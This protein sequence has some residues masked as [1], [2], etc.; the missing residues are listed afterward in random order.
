MESTGSLVTTSYIFMAFTEFTVFTHNWCQNW[1]QN[2]TY[3]YFPTRSVPLLPARAPALGVASSA[4]EYPRW[5]AR[6]SPRPWPPGRWHDASG[7]RRRRS[8]PD[9]TAP[10][11]RVTGHQRDYILRLVRRILRA[12]GNTARLTHHDI[13][14]SRLTLQSLLYSS[15]KTAIG[16]TREARRAGIKQATSAT[17]VKTAPTAARVMGSVVLTP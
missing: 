3:V 14:D 2:Q 10:Y 5:T 7:R 4:V 13:G 12:P 6:A 9:A 16:S 15:C 11:T 17:T 8:R 1:C